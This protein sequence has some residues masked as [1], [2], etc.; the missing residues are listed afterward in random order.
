MITP[1][2]PRFTLDHDGRHFEVESESAGLHTIAR[3]YVDGKRV[4]EQK[5]MDKRLQL[6]GGGLSVAVEFNWLGQISEILALPD[7]VDSSRMAEEGIAFA[8]P[9]GSRAARLETLR[10]E[11]PVLYAARHVVLAS[12]QVLI[13]AVGLGALV[14]GLL[15]RLPIPNIPLPDIPEIPWPAIDLPAIPWPDLPLP[16]FDLLDLSHL[17]WLKDLW[18]SVNW[19]V[20]IIIAIIVAINELDKRR[21]REAGQKGDG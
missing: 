1:D 17:A 10:R 7:D 16:A 3:L 4:D 11:H 15:P 13:G 12:L 19:L 21:K 2:S 8:A 9:P 18:N 6:A 5:G 20:P 14:W